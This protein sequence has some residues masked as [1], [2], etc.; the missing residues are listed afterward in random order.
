MKAVV[1]QA[2]K[3]SHNIQNQ[4]FSTTVFCH[5]KSISHHL[6]TRSKKEQYSNRK[7]DL[8]KTPPLLRVGLVAVSCQRSTLQ[9]LHE[10]RQTVDTDIITTA[11]RH[12]NNSVQTSLLTRAQFSLPAVQI[13]LQRLNR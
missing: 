1:R 7:S 2:G 8:D 4:T 6:N 9:A 11:Q 3:T 13:G 5:V 12:C 10:R